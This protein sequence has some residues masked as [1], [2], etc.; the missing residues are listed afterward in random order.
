MSLDFMR[1]HQNCGWLY[2]IE[3]LK[4]RQKADELQ[5]WT[6]ACER[7]SYWLANVKTKRHKQDVA[8][9]QSGFIDPPSVERAR[10]GGSAAHVW[11]LLLFVVGSI[12]AVS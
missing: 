10:T 11:D 2:E 8:H 1:Q 7:S 4:S 12:P 5:V 9:V 3:Q 6:E